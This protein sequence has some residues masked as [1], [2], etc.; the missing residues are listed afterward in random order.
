MTNGARAGGALAWA[1][2]A[3]LGC[4]LVVDAERFRSPTATP[5]S[6]QPTVVDEGSYAVFWIGP[7]DRRALTATVEPEDVESIDFAATDGAAAVTVR[8]PVWTD[9][10]AGQSRTLRITLDY[11]DDLQTFAA[12]VRGLDEWSGTAAEYPASAPTYSRVILTGSGDPRGGSDPFVVEATSEIRIEGGLE[13]SA[14]DGTPGPGGWAGGNSGD[15]SGPAGGPAGA[16]GGCPAAGAGGGNRTP[17]SDGG[18]R[19][20]ATTLPAPASL[21]LAELGGSGGGAGGADGGEPGRPG[22][23]GGGI[24]WARSGGDLAWTGGLRARGGAGAASFRDGCGQQFGASGGGGA[25]GAVVLQAQTLQSL[26][27]VDVSGGPGGPD[28]RPGGN[29][30]DGWALAGTV[31]RQPPSGF[32]RLATWD[33]SRT[34]VGTERRAVVWGPPGGRAQVTVDGEP[35]PSL[36]LDAS[37]RAEVDLAAEP[38]RVRVCARDPSVPTFLEDC[39]WVGV[40]P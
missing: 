36:Q 29:G 40:L 16:D 32:A 35:T 19:T 9:L 33:R 14:S 3:T 6:V 27:S 21:T 38:G 12:Q 24:L 39:T 34:I 31:G 37:G 5:P 23:G 22:G 30:G 7:T 18:G 1:L 11:G 17:G 13:L 10:N 25:G 8:L 28:Q 20:Q 15:G 2:M 26:G 4:S